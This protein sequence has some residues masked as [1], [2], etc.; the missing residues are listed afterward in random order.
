[1]K[2]KK[3]IVMGGRVTK[4][5]KS[6]MD[7]LGANVYDAVK[8]FLTHKDNSEVKTL[9]EIKETLE[10]NNT[11]ANQIVRNNEKLEELKAEIKFKGTNEDLYDYIFNKD[12]SNA[13][14]TTLGYFDTWNTK[15]YS[16]EE[17]ISLKNDY[18]QIQANKCSLDVEEFE[19]KLLEKYYGSTQT[20]L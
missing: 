12:I 15:D 5:M 3:D 8:F 11:I 4:H 20:T 13:L 9:V 7:K 14:E 6:E 2:E 17:F 10:Q 1:M 19:G 16:L 18:I